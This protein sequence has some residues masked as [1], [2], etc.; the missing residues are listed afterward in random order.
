MDLRENKRNTWEGLKGEK[1]K[2]EMCNYTLKE[3]T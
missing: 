1:K 2:R 3:I